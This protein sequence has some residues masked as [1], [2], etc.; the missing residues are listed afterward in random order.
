MKIYQLKDSG[1]R[2]WFIG[3]FDRAIWK[4]DA[5]EVAYQFSP[6]GSIGPR[7][8]HRIAKE[9]NLITQ[10]CVRANGVI[11][12]SGEIYEVLPGEAAEC[13]YIEDIQ[14]VT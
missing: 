13:E 14:I 9:I 7:H 1:E 11:V 5:F 10:G 4:T 12:Q 2:G 8:V 6:K 3:D